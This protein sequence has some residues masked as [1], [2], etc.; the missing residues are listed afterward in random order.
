MKKQ[1][2]SIDFHQ[3]EL[4]LCE[5]TLHSARRHSKV[6]NLTTLVADCIF[7]NAERSH[8]GRGYTMGFSRRKTDCT[9]VWEPT[10]TQKK[11]KRE[12]EKKS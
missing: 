8:P 6:L 7:H 11:P 4:Y 1:M 9:L 10:E 2:D 3:E 12:R 5:F